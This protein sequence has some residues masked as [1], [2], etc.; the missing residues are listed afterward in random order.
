MTEL[1]PAEEQ[2]RQILIERATKTDL[3]VPRKALITY[4]DLCA[5]ADPDQVHW[6]WP[7][8]RGIGQ[9]LGHI[10]T[11][12]YDH[13]RPLLSALVVQKQTMRAGDGFANDLGRGLG[14]DILPGD[15]R[16]FWL[17]QVEMVVRYW[18]GR[19]KDATAPDPVS[20]ARAR[21]A[22]VTNELDSIRRLLELA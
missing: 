10:S 2:V 3:R 17:E 8:Y 7:R 14:F 1:T 15:E 16:R 18:T 12:E 4:H 13:G 5:S 11:Y 19:G 20:E 6:K 22:A 21:L 9:A